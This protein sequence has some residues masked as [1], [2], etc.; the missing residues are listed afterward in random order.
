MVDV[1]ALVKAI[2]DYAALLLVGDIDQLPQTQIPKR[3]GLTASAIS[4]CS[5]R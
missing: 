4:R 1:Q 3:C 5:V 2:P